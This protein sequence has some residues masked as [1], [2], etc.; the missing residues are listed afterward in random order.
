MRKLPRLKAGDRVSV[1]WFDA[2]E[3]CESWSQEVDYAAEY[4][5][6]SLGAYLFTGK[7]YMAISG[8]VG[9]GAVGRVFYIP[10]GMVSRVRKI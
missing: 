3:L 6:T 5:V 8:D 7:R 1:E 4:P 10:L 2:F 9:V